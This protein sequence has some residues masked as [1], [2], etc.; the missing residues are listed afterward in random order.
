MESEPGHRHV[1]HLYGIYPS[2]IFTE[3]KRPDQFAA[4]KKS[5]DFR[6]AQGGGHTG[7]SRAWTACF[8]ARFGDGNMVREH[9]SELVRSYTTDSLLDTHPYYLK[10]PPIAFQIDGNFGA[11]AAI[12]ETV[13]QFKNGKLYLLPA[14]PDQWQNGSVKGY[15]TPGGNKVVF[16]WENGVVTEIC[17]TIGFS[18]SLTLTVNGETKT[19]SGKAGKTIILK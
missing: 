7:W 19:V 14:L 16:A 8:Y 9:M 6:V 13:A 18:E 5:M 10:N 4:A 11:V 3:E 17:V 12:N 15:C 1:S 2:D